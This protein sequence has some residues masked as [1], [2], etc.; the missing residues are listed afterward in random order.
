MD[1]VKVITPSSICSSHPPVPKKIMSSSAVYI[2]CRNEIPVCGSYD[3]SNN[4]KE[5]FSLSLISN[6]W[7]KFANLRSPRANHSLTYFP[8][9]E[10]LVAISGKTA[11]LYKLGDPTWA[12]W[13]VPEQRQIYGYCSFYIY[14]VGGGS[15]HNAQYNYVLRMDVNNI[16]QPTWQAMSPMPEKKSYAACTLHGDIFY[17]AGGSNSSETAYSYNITKDN[18]TD[19]S[20]LVYGREKAGLSVIGGV[21]TAFGGRIWITS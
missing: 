17:V 4:V 9:H 12:D 19:I 20:F 5:C 15:F 11:E 3:E 7:T 2:S 21:L 6:E 8:D 13:T 14:I 18:W 16:I 1:T 10:M